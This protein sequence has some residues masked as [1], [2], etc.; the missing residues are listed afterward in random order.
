MTP[1]SP[2]TT[3]NWWYLKKKIIQ[4]ARR[5]AFEFVQGKAPILPQDNS[6]ASINLIGKVLIEGEDAQETVKL[7]FELKPSSREQVLRDEEV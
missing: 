6:L 2:C 1:L 5:E 3:T 4:K 7:C